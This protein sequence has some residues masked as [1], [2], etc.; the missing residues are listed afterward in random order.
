MNKKLEAIKERFSVAALKIGRGGGKAEIIYDIQWLIE[1][2]EE[3]EE[4]Q[5]ESKLNLLNRIDNSRVENQ[6]LKAENERFKQALEFYANEEK[7]EE[8]LIPSPESITQVAEDHGEI[9][10]RAL[11]GLK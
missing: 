6:R 11:K 4:L 9:A 5:M 8:I 3:L 10:Q 1:R 7:Y 2:V